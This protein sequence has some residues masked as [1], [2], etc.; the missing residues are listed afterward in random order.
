MCLLF[1]IVENFPVYAGRSTQ[2]ECAYFFEELL[3]VK[4]YTKYT[5]NHHFDLRGSDN[6][7][8][9]EVM[10]A[11]SHWSNRHYHGKRMV[12]DLQGVGCV[13]T[14]PLIVDTTS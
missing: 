1:Q 8:I 10:Q 6:P 2:P 11:L 12:A 5:S 4:K 7:S 13:L 9:K 14:D 3:D